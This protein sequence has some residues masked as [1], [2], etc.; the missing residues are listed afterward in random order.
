MAVRLNPGARVREFTIRK[1]IFSGGEGDLYQAAAP[2]GRLVA[3]KQL[4]FSP[5]DPVHRE[6]VERARRHERLIRV[7][8]PHI[9]EILTVFEHE[10][11][12]YIAMEWVSGESLRAFLDREKRM[13]I[14][15]VI[16][17]CMHVLEA[18]V[19]LNERNIVHRDIKPENIMMIPSPLGSFTVVLIDLGISLHL[20]L[21]RLTIDGSVG[22]PYYAAPEVITGGDMEIGFN[23]DLFSLG[24]TAFEAY[25]G[26]H[27]FPATS[28]IDLCGKIFS[29]ERPSIRE[30][31]PDVHPAFEDY[32]QTLMRPLSKD[33]YVS[34]AQALEVLKRIAFTEEK[35]CDI[36][37]K[38]EEERIDTHLAKP[39]KVPE[40]IP[41]LIVQSGPYRD[42]RITV[43][44]KGMCLGRG[45]INPE[46]R[47]ISRFHVFVVP[48]KDGLHVRD[49]GSKSGLFSKGAPKRGIR[50]HPGE[51]VTLGAS[52]LKF[53]Y[54]WR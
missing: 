51:E 26:E 30:I 23:A 2:G 14:D 12:L 28:L 18:L 4:N 7:K 25:T 5:S 22:T 38:P 33:R 15:H 40:P 32:I 31:I 41:V 27:P 48:C 9:A 42:K 3:L 10:G 17:L 20:G 35:D 39:V 44:T 47:S 21:S 49:L 36:G 29:P 37:C 54:D 45:D 50:L 19:F 13:S 8:H 34:P 46:D 6:G 16:L 52:V 11:L 1:Y 43:P 24:V 53:S